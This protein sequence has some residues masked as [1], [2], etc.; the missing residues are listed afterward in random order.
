MIH[1]TSTT[2]EEGTRKTNVFSRPPSLH[3]TLALPSSPSSPSIHELNIQAVNQEGRGSA[4]SDPA[5]AE[6]WSLEHAHQ[7]LGVLVPL[8]RAILVD[9]VDQFLSL[10]LRDGDA[11][12]RCFPVLDLCSIFQSSS[13]SWDRSSFK[14]P[15]SSPLADT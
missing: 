14:M 9:L 13:S 7:R 11:R 3:H 10:A 6:R 4:S 5:M 8:L 2:R 1:G 15:N 12:H